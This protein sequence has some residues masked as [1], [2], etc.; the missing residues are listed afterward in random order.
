M[1]DRLAEDPTVGTTLK[2]VPD[3]FIRLEIDYPSFLKKLQILNFKFIKLNRNIFDRTISFSFARQTN[4]WNKQKAADGTII[5]DTKD[6]KNYISNPT[7]IHIP[8]ADFVQHYLLEQLYDYYG[9]L[10]L[11]NVDYNIIN[12]ATLLDDCVANNI[13]I[14]TKEYTITHKLYDIPY[15]SLILNYNELTEIYKRLTNE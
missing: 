12:Y 11:K 8:P 2:I 9:D 6:D 3:S 10:Y 1:F 14:D 13:I 5:Y 4:I 7:P 15:K